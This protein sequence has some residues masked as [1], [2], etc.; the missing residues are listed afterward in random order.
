MVL[1]LFETKQKDPEFLKISLELSF[2]FLLHLKNV[3]VSFS[4]K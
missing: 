4:R 1:V 2:K 3:I